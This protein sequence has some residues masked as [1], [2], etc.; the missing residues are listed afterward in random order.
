METIEHCAY[1]AV[2]EVGCELVKKRVGNFFQLFFSI[3]FN[4]AFHGCID[5]T[6]K[7]NSFAFG[8]SHGTQVN[9][10]F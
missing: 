10:R 5:I 6:I 7:R 9:I 8:V 1:N 3:L 2:C 4:L